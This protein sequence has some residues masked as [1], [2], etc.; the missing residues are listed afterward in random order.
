MSI[1]FHVE[2]AAAALLLAGLLPG[3]AHAVDLKLRAV[4]I[5]GG[6]VSATESP[7][8]GE[9]L[10]VLEEDND[11]RLDLSYAGFVTGSTGAALHVGK[12]NENGLKIAD[13]DVSL[14]A[15]EGRLSIEQLRLDAD[16][17]AR[18]RA[19]E[20]YLVI[21]TIQYPN[22]AIRGQLVP[23]PLRVEDLPVE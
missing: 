15:T 7:A 9:A 12:E 5:G 16:D 1:R 3:I 20:S 8:T 2:A 23:Q 18:V 22:G 14:D 19:G 4:L 11:L 10:A 6:V 13:L 21:S 17:A